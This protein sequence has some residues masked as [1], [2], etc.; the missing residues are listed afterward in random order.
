M[1]FNQNKD[2]TAS[3]WVKTEVL[4]KF[5]GRFVSAERIAGRFVL[6]IRK[7]GL[8]RLDVN[9]PSGDVILSHFKSSSIALASECFSH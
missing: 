3:T 5:V 9:P 7:K 8:L 4:H 1:F 2:N 6:K